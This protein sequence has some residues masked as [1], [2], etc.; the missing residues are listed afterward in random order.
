MTRSESVAVE[1]VPEDGVVVADRGFGGELG[2]QRKAAA[3]LHR[4]RR[5][6][7]RI[8]RRQIG[9]ETE[10]SRFLHRLIQTQCRR[11]AHAQILCGCG[12]CR[13]CDICRQAGHEHR[14]GEKNPRAPRPATNGTWM[15]IHDYCPFP[16]SSLLKRA[17]RSSICLCNAAF[18]TASSCTA[19][20]VVINAGLG[21]S[22]SIVGSFFAAPGRC[23]LVLIT[24]VGNTSA[25]SCAI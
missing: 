22:A 16:V 14:N 15:G 21:S 17:S 10:R 18:S 9:F 5:C 4:R 2:D 8:F 13:K 1:I 20:T 19:A 7:R 25:Y 12:F 23:S 24:S 11:P 3:V 6:Q